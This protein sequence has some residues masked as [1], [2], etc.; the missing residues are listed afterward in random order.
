MS[1]SNNNGIITHSNAEEDMFQSSKTEELDSCETCPFCVGAK[2]V[3][4]REK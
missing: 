4:R 3:G 2:K 1:M